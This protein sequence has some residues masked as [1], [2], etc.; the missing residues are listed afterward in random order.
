MKQEQI[1]KSKLNF[2]IIISIFLGYSMIYMD[3]SMISIA[4]RPIAEQ[5]QLDSGQTGMIM[6][7]FFLGY[8][9]MQIPGGWLADKLGSKRVLLLSLAI[10]TTFSFV[11]GIASGLIM[12]IFIRFLQGVGH[13]GYPPSCSKSIAENFPKEKRTFV[14]SLMLSTSGIGGVLAYTIGAAVIAINWRNS[15]FLLGSIYLLAFILVFIFVPNSKPALNVNQDN[16]NKVK[17]TKLIKNRNILILFI[18]MLLINFQLYGNMSWLPSY[19]ADKFT[20]STAEASMLLVPNAIVQTVATLSA[21]ALVSKLFLK[22][23]AKVIICCA[24]LSALFI[25][26]FIMSNNVVLSVILLM[27]TTFA[28]ITIFTTIFTWPHKIFEQSEIGSVIGV[29]NTGGTLGGFLAPLVL[30]FLIK[31]TGGY[32]VSFIFLAV[33]TVVCGLMMLFIRNKA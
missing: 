20:L 13:A 9:I 23:E 8:S 18:A 22:K 1:S 24:I 11:F 14:Q 2:G 4:I 32:E 3:K 26:G 12:F 27:L 19:L 7:L 6:S 15:Y 29:V 10:I 31:N 17:F 21:G 25:I 16:K 30:G 28:A 5:Y 33:A